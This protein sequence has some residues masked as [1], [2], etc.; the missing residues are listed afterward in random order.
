MRCA[1]VIASTWSCVTYRVVVP[2][3]W[4]SACSSLRICTRSLASRLDSGSSNRNTLG[5]RTMAR[6]IATRW[7]WPPES[8]RGRRLSSLREL[9]DLRRALHALRRSP[10]SAGPGSSG[11]RPCCRTRSCAGRARS[12]G[13]PWRCRGPSA[14]GRSPRAR[15]W[16][17]RPQVMLSSPATMR[18]SVDLPQ[19]E[20]PTITTNSPSLMSIEMP[21]ITLTAPKDLNT[22]RIDTAAIIS[23]SPPGP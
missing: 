6:P 12:S 23:R 19:P 15:R 21:W 4:C 17:S 5:S 20:G 14:P 16:R 8:S 10:P 2:R 9:E 13:T 1:S 11:R 18:S 3:R 7:R 22:L